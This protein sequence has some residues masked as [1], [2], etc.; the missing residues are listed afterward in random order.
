MFFFLIEVK[1]I[2]GIDSY[3]I[4]YGTFGVKSET[5]K[6]IK[7]N[8]THFLLSNQIRGLFTKTTANFDF[9]NTYIQEHFKPVA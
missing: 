4:D 8:A 9:W 7:N 6:Y 1:G 2:L 5:V 3:S